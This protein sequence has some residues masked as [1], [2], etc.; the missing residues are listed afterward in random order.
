MLV[1]A[2]VVGPVVGSG[3]VILQLSL[4][5]AWDTGLP[6]TS[7]DDNFVGLVGPGNA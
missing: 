2:G 5:Q 1:C 6:A 4:P 3:S 7:S